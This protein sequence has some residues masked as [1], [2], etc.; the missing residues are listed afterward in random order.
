MYMKKVIGLAEAQA[1]LQAMIEKAKSGKPMAFAI[2]DANGDLVC[3]ARMDGARP[4]NAFMAIKKAYSAA[5]MKRDTRVIGSKLKEY[6]RSLTDSY[7]PDIT[8]VPGGNIIIEP[9]GEELIGA[10]GASGRTSDED[11]ALVREG[12]KILLNNLKSPK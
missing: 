1:A 11:E 12:V 8:M 2:A 5:R 10:I 9:D 3:V 6:G 7:G 4:F